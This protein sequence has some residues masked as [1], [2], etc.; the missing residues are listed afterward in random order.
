MLRWTNRLQEHLESRG[1]SLCKWVKGS[2]AVFRKHSIREAEFVSCPWE[3]NGRNS[4]PATPPTFTISMLRR[5]MFQ[6]C[7]YH[8][9]IIIRQLEEYPDEIT[10]H[11]KNEPTDD[12]SVD[13]LWLSKREFISRLLI[14][15]SYPDHSYGLYSFKVASASEGVDDSLGLRVYSV[16]QLFSGDHKTEGFAL[17]FL[18][19][20]TMPMISTQIAMDLDFSWTTVGPP[21]H[22]VLSVIPNQAQPLTE[23]WDITLIS[24]SRDLVQVLSENPFHPNVRL[25]L[26][27]PRPHMEITDSIRIANLLREFNHLRHLKVCHGMLAGAPLVV[28]QVLESV[29]I[30]ET[31]NWFLFDNVTERVFRSIKQLEF[32]WHSLTTRFGAQA[33]FDRNTALLCRR[34]CNCIRMSSLRFGTTY[35]GK[36]SAIKSNI[37]WDSL[38]FPVLAINWLHVGENAMI[39]NRFMGLAV[40]ATN[41]GVVFAKTTNVI[42]FDASVANASAVYVLFRHCMSGKRSRSEHG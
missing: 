33:W 39:G 40:Q 34:T 32:E 37:Q 20:L 14:T 18:S 42:P 35:G 30:L 31:Q 13:I 21:L 38:F 2:D 7:L 25:G 24:P 6:G 3:A 8:R 10:S 22:S 27:C 23:F 12:D 28:N 16:E 11:A 15:Y 36:K 9:A 26:T 4:G 19:H 29:T 1:E 5:I 17:K 41:Q